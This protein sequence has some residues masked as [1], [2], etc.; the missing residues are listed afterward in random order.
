MLNGSSPACLSASLTRMFGGVPINVFRPPSSAAN[1]N[2]ISSLDGGIFVRRDISIT[3]GRNSDATPISFINPESTPTVS[4]IISSRRT[5][6]EPA[7]RSN[8]RPSS[9]A[10]PVRDSAALRIRIAHTV[11]TAGLLKPDSASAGVTRPVS[12][13]LTSTISATRSSRTRSVMNSTTAASRITRTV[14]ISRVMPHLPR[15]YCT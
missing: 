5:S 12:A 6:L 9:P 13:R 4:I 1:A 10:T 14:M 2:G 11:T 15:K 7:R 8:R 3:T